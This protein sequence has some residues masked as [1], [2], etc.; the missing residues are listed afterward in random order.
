MAP[1]SVTVFDLLCLKD[2]RNL[3]EETGQLAA[4]IVSEIKKIDGCQGVYFGRKI[5]KHDAIEATE[6]L[7]FEMTPPGDSVLKSPCTECFTAYGVEDGFADNVLRF[8]DKADAEPPAGY[9]GATI[10]TGLES[11]EKGIVRMLIGWSSKAAH[12]QAKEIAGGGESEC[13]YTKVLRL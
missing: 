7:S 9:Y 11:K 4:G 1:A 6:T 10:G 12:L 3:N 5:E 2:N 8:V 13:G